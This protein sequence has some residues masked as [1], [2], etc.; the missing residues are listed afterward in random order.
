MTKE[1]KKYFYKG[2]EY[3]EDD[4][5][6]MDKRKRYEIKNRSKRLI[7]VHNWYEKHSDIK[8]QYA[9]DYYFYKN[10]VNR[11]RSIEI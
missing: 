5:R 4:L 9:R 11:L 10:E 1:V 2:N 7:A 6:E 3:T 8:K